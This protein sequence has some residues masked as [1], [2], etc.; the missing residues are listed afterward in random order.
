MPRYELGMFSVVANY[1]VL[2]EKP[3]PV[4]YM[5]AMEMHSRVEKVSFTHCH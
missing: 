1:S 3:I 5:A 2:F 4:W